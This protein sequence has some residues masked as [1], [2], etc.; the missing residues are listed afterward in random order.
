M[1]LHAQRIGLPFLV[2]ERVVKKAFDRHAVRTFPLD[3]FLPR[4]Q[5]LLGQVVEDVCD[6]LWSRP[7]S[8]VEHL[9]VTGIGPI[10]ERHDMSVE[11]WLVV[12][13]PKRMISLRDLL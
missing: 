6:P 5:E 11:L 12:V 13:A 9:D 1:G 8:A 4:Y 3:G 2:V 10:I 7:V